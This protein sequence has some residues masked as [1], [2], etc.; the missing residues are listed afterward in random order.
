MVGDIVFPIFTSPVHVYCE[1]VVSVSINRSF[2]SSL[3]PDRFCVDNRLIVPA[4]Y[5]FKH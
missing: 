4:L 1:S 3:V 5:L 2:L